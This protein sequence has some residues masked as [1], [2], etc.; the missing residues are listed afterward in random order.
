MDL[1]PFIWLVVGVMGTFAAALA[2][3]S[4]VTRGR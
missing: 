3:A 2:W 1:D 4:W